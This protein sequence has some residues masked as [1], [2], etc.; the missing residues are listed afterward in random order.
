MTEQVHPGINLKMGRPGKDL[1]RVL[2]VAVLQQGLGCDYDRLQE[3]ANRRQTVRE[4]LGHS[5]GFYAERTSHY[6]VIPVLLLIC[7]ID[8]SASY[9]KRNISLIFRIVNLRFAIPSSLKWTSIAS[10]FNNIGKVPEFAVL[11]SLRTGVHF[12]QNSVFTLNKN[13][14]SL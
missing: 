6:Q 13:R 7:L 3:L 1:W 9:L 10:C 2:V 5:D 8:L 4:M 12:E 11:F 14:F